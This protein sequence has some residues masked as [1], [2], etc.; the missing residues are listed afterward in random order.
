MSSDT[1]RYIIG[2]TLATLTLGFLVVMIGI[3]MYSFI[4]NAYRVIVAVLK[5]IYRMIGSMIK[6][7]TDIPDYMKNKWPKIKEALIKAAYLVVFTCVAAFMLYCCFNSDSTR[8]H[9]Q[10]KI[11]DIMDDPQWNVPSRYRE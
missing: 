3:W 4:A 11:E 2:Y 5:F 8:Y 1:I 6:Y 10:E 7:V 9:N